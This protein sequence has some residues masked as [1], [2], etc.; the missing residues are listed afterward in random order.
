MLLQRKSNESEID[1]LLRQ[2][3]EELNITQEQMDE[4]MKA[5]ESKFQFFENNLFYL[6]CD[7]GGDVIELNTKIKNTFNIEDPTGPEF[8]LDIIF[9]QIE[10]KEGRKNSYLEK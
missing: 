5:I 10:L 2:Q 3:L 8:N 4:Q 7:H 1:D 6:I 9:E